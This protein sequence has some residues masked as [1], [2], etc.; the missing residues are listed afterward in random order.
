MGGSFVMFS[1]QLRDA[2]GMAG[3]ND[4]S[5]SDKKS[6]EAIND[7]PTLNTENMQSNMKVIYYRFVLALL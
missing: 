1:S 7:L 5:A 2:Q 3:H 6:S 4:S